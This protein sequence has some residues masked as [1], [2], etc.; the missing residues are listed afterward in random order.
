M[1]I[2]ELAAL[3]GSTVRTIRYYHQIGL[4]PV[5]GRR[6]GARDYDMSHLARLVRVRWLAQ[7]G[8]PLATIA[9]VLDDQPGIDPP[10][11]GASRES[12]L[13][14]LRASVVAVDEQLAELRGQRERITGLIAAVEAG[15]GLS[16]MPPVVARFYD[17]MEARAGDGKARRLIR[18]ERDFMEVAFYRGEMPPE[19]ALLYQGLTE[20]AMARSLDQFRAIADRAEQ[21]HLLDDREIAQIADG[22]VERITRHLGPDLPR[23]MKAVDLDLARRAADLYLGLADPRHRRIDRAI[24]DA[25]LTAIEK[26]QVQ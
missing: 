6:D 22:V 12:V 14:D 5:P 13:A 10:G 11:Q 20:A 8:I 7:A 24:A 26:G 2:K 17:E 21:V 4:L 3:T 15:G 16:P 1:R 18:R 19:S 9:T 23:L 25:L